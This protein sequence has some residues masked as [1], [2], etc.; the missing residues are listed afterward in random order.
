MPDR[1]VQQV[2]ENAV[3]TMALHP[4]SAE[5]KSDPR[6]RVL[7]NAIN[8]MLWSERHKLAELI[9][10]YSIMHPDVTDSE[11]LCEEI[12][13]MVRDRNNSPLVPYY[14]T[15]V[16]A[17][18]VVVQSYVPHFLFI[19]R[20]HVI[21]D[22]IGDDMLDSAIPAMI[23][24][25]WRT[26][27]PVEYAVDILEKMNQVLADP[28]IPRYAYIRSD[29]DVPR[30]YRLK[31]QMNAQRTNIVVHCQLKVAQNASF[32]QQPLPVIAVAS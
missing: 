7:S 4:M 16:G 3:L 11:Q 13:D 23:G 14:P 2:A 12:A 24:C 22:V 30:E 19:I 29:R 31:I 8:G 6:V 21:Q 5:P 15:A 1:T 27:L 25:D 28:S 18:P 9:E 20:D 32:S 17:T 26:L 10:E